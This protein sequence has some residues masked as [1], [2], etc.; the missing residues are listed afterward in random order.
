MSTMTLTP[1]LR[2]AQFGPQSQAARL[3]PGA[4]R[5]TRRGRL[6]IL[7]AFVLLA[8]AAMIAFGGLATATHDSGT[9]ESV[10]VV[11]VAPGD[12]LFGIAGEVSEPGKIRETVAHIRALN[13]MSGSS[14]Q[15][16][17]KIAV[18]AG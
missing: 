15:V 3:S 4:L 10:R 12:T 17:D 16:G 18:P 9:P 14:L 2:S 8:V 5:L 6:V 11:T 13:S 1:R 7:A